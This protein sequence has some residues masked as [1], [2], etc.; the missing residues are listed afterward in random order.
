M[1]LYVEGNKRT[2]RFITSLGILV[3]GF[4]YDYGGC[5]RLFHKIQSN[6]PPIIKQYHTHN[7]VQVVELPKK[8][9]VEEEICT[10]IDGCRIVDNVCIDCV[11]KMAQI[12]SGV[13]SSLK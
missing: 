13:S 4:F 5:N 7:T 11:D 1:R 9:I 10:R 3:F 12:S 2:G 6:Q 8:V